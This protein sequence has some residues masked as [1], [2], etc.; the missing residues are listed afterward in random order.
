METFYSGLFDWIHCKNERT[1][2]LDDSSIR[3]TT[4]VTMRAAGNLTSVGKS[5]YIINPIRTINPT[6]ADIMN[7][8]FSC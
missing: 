6:T 1:Y 4:K 7:R 2:W 5:V 8:W 3:C